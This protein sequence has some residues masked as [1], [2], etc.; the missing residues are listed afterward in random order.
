MF[1]TNY[2][3]CLD[4]LEL[5]PRLVLMRCVWD[6]F[7][8]RLRCVRIPRCAWC[9]KKVAMLVWG[10]LWRL[11]AFEFRGA[12][13][14]LKQ[15]RCS[16]EERSG[17]SRVTIM[18]ATLD[19]P[20]PNTKVRYSTRNSTFEGAYGAKWLGTRTRCPEGT[21]ADFVNELFADLE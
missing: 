16:F 13:D 3:M 14:V 9:V 10:A 6:A 15:L 5:V 11:D 7:E 12:L 19:W 1:E 17:N 2:L 8:M 4:A 21:V 18:F 20:L